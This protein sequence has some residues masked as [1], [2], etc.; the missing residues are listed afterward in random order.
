MSSLLI[1]KG[2]HE[3]K[4]Q[5]FLYSLSSESR[6]TTAFPYHPRPPHWEVHSK[7]D[8]SL[9]CRGVVPAQV[10]STLLCPGLACCGPDVQQY[11]CRA[12]SRSGCRRDHCAC[13]IFQVDVSPPSVSAEMISTHLLIS[14]QPPSL[15]GS[16]SSYF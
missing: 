1:F 7:H 5:I 6:G 11:A 15:P 4:L 12:S 10:S 2:A 9:S 16:I 3:V 14:V 8:A 13:C